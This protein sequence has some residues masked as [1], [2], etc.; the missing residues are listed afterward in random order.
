VTGGTLRINGSAPY[1]TFAVDNGTLAGSGTVGALALNSG[2]TLSPGNSPGILNAGG[3]T[4]AGGAT[5]LWEINNATGTAGTGWDLLNITGAL[6]ITATSANPFRLDLTSLTLAN[7]AGPAANFNAA[8][9]H[10]FLIASASLGVTGFDTSAFTIDT[11]DFANPFGG[12]WSVALSG[13]DI[14]LNYSVSAIPEPS[15]YAAIA[16][17]LGLVAAWWRRHRLAPRDSEN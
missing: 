12:S 15:T 17:L 1:S 3:T 5:Y 13:S 6:A 14:Q 8:Q 4:W 2:G 11:A 7:A 10:T 9:N 16:G